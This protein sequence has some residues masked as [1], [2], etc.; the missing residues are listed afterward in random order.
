[1]RVRNRRGVPDKRVRQRYRKY[2]NGYGRGGRRQ[3]PEAAQA[4]QEDSVAEY[5][6]DIYGLLDR[7]EGRSV[8]RCDYMA[9]QP[10]LNAGMRA[11]LVDWLVFVAAGQKLKLETLF[12]TVNIVDRFLDQ[13]QTTRQR[14]Q[15]VGVAAMRI[16]SKFEEFTAIGKTAAVLMTSSAYTVDDV[17]RMEVCILTAL[18]FVICVPTAAHFLR[19]FQRL[20]KCPE[21]SAHGHLMHYLLE[22]ALLDLR[23][24]RYE[25]SRLVAAAALLSNKLRKQQPSWPPRL[26]SHCKFDL[27]AVRACAQEMCSIFEAAAASPLQAVRTKFSH[28]DFC[29]VATQPWRCS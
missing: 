5:E 27:L 25:P 28:Q 1:M 21:D 23:M 3:V 20:N 29:S 18:K 17:L 10:D 9:S 4:M 7:H 8:P 19:R 26:A 15:L 13:R 6:H 16:A 11:I 2:E 22:L 14:L 24:T 12:L